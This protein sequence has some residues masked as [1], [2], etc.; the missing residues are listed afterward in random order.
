MREEAWAALRAAGAARFPGVEGRIPNFVGAEA[1]AR[2]L[3]ETGV[4]SDVSAIKA[5]PDSPQWPVRTW[6]LQAGKLLYMAVPRLREEKPF[7]R[8]DLARLSVPPRRACSI[9][10]AAEHGLPV[11]LGEMDRIDLLVC[12]SVAVD[13]SGARLGKGG[14]YSDLEF[15]L[16]V[17][18]GLIGPWTT[19]ATTVHPS[20]VIEDGKIPMTAHDFPVDL[21][22]TSEEVIETSGARARPGG[23]LWDHLSPDKLDTVPVLQERVR[24]P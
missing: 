8:L 12:G 3:S 5:N 20:Q 1:A 24:P 6:A 7:W 19:I 13:P 2:R 21:I 18:A 4:W 15:G 10:G 14:G 22:V 16:G 11:G 9:R 23:I 17:E